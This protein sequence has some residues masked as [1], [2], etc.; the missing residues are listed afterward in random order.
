MVLTIC[1][2]SASESYW[3][4]CDIIDCSPPG[5]SVHGIFLARILDRGCHFLLQGIFPIQGSNLHLLLGR[6]ILYH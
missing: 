4:L 2:C 5:S 6:Q 1:V 3:T